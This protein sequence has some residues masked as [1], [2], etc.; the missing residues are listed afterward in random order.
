MTHFS[1]EQDILLELLAQK[2]PELNTQIL[3]YVRHEGQELPIYGFT[4]GS[5]VPD[6]FTVC[7][8]GGVHGLERI[9][10]HVVFAFLN[11]VVRE[12]SWDTLWAELLKKI[13]IVSVPVVNP[14]GVLNGSRSNGRG[15]DL[16][17][18]APLDAEVSVTPLVGGHRISRNLPWYRGDNIKN[19]KAGMETE[20]RALVE[21]VEQEV[22]PAPGSIILDVHSGF[23]FKDRL[24]YPFAGLK[25]RFPYEN[26]IRTITNI[27]N[28]TLPHHVYTVEPQEKI[29][30]T[31][32]D[33][34]DY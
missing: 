20:S 2:L 31:H 6:R 23:G 22:F 7:L 3:D 19:K 5:K 33:L 10:T 29:Y 4:I 16:M 21:F 28:Q 15:V 34:W 18:N 14:V 12:L 9:G 30:R 26:Q 11:K 27:L 25:D 17:R 13:R 1:D 8:V 32:G 24:W